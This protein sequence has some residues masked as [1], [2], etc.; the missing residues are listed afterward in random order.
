VRRLDARA[1]EFERELARIIAFES[2]Q[3]ERVDATVAQI[4]DDVR[5]RGDA[6]LIELTARFD[7]VHATS[8]A[9]LEV[10]AAEM[11]RAFDALPEAERAALTTAAARIRAYHE[12]QVLASWSFRDADGSELGQ[13]IT[14]L[15]SVGVYV[16]GGKARTPRRC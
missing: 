4:I 13:R 6:A 2:S 9:E 8:M 1:P 3:D 14:P 16:P 10:T 15:D 11:R 7:G 5:A 12:R